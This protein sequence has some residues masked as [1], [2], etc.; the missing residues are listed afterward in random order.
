MC[1]G[2]LGLKASNSSHGN[3]VVEVCMCMDNVTLDDERP[4]TT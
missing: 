3:G 2:R 4:E 1:T